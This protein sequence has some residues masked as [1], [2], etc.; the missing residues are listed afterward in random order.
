[1][2][3]YE[4]GERISSLFYSYNIG[5]LFSYVFYHYMTY[6]LTECDLME[7]I[8]EKLYSITR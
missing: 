2:S 6:N 4:P 8:L 7:L 1:M 5:M 3:L